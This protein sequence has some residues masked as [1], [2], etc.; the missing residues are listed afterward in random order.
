M[1]VVMSLWGQAAFTTVIYLARPAGRPRR[2][3][4]GGPDRRR[5]QLADLLARGVAAAGAVT[6]FVGIYQTLQAVQLFDLVY[7]TTRGGPL[8]ATQTIVYYSVE[9]GLPEP[10]VRATGPPSPTACSSTLTATVNVTARAAPSRNGTRH[11]DR[12]DPSISRPRTGR[13]PS[14]HRRSAPHPVV[15]VACRSARGNSC[16]HRGAPLPAAV[17]SSK[18]VFEVSDR[19]VPR[20]ST[21]S[22]RRSSPT[23]FTLSGYTRLFA[24]SDILP[25]APQHGHRVASAIVSH[26]VLCSL[27]RVRVR[28]ACGS[29]GGRSGSW[30]SS[31]R[32]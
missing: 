23:Q 7:A 20:R 1:I 29:R 31:R 13:T 26:L 14:R 9:D 4:R 8:D 22:R 2:R 19:T 3:A 27:G 32:S 18:T 12:R 15:D 17:S 10:A 16:S 24:E 5:E 11:D 30:R 28:A 21:S 25:L 6:A